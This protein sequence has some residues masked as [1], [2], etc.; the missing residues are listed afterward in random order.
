MLLEKVAIQPAQQPSGLFL[1]MFYILNTC[2]CLE[3]PNILLPRGFHRLSF[4]IISIIMAASGRVTFVAR[5]TRVNRGHMP[6]GARQDK[7]YED[8]ERYEELQ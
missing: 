8:V 7:G 5:L 6:E 1:K 2:L 3:L 4:F